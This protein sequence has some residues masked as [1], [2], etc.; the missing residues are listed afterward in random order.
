[1]RVLL[2]GGTGNISASLTRQLVEAGHETW[3]VNRGKRNPIPGTRQVSCDARDEAALVAATAG[4][5]FDAVLDFIA[6][7]P[8]DVARDARVFAG[9][10]AQYIFVSSASVYQ[11]PLARYLVT[12]STPLIN[13]YWDYSRD[14]I[15]CEEQCLELLCKQGFPT[16]IIRPSLTY[17]TVIPTALGGWTD[18]TLVDRVKR[19][20]PVVAM[21]TA[22][23]YG[24]SPTPR[25][26]AGHSTV[27]SAIRRRSARPFTS[28]A[29]R[30]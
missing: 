1:M 13:P 28:P 27:C 20:V 6:F 8:E 16:V 25:T 19:G 21:G 9:R 30:C 4:T 3:L 10:T 11:K 12:E 29:T 26:S 14:K 17:D 2:L 24:P 15:A 5:T 22:R 23:R 7:K 18:Y